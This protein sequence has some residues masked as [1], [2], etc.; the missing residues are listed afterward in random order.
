MT[1]VS[2]TTER[3][4]MKSLSLLLAATAMLVG[5]ASTAAGNGPLSECKGFI[6]DA[7]GRTLYTFKKDL[8]NQSN[9]F[10][11][12]AKVW[13]PFLVADRS[14][15]T[16]DLTVVERKDGTAQWAWKAQPLY[17]YSGDAE[18]RQVNGDGNGGTWFALR[19]ATQASTG[20]GY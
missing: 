15:A 7:Q 13:P 18:A 9:C 10:D 19:P 1:L 11:N 4:D 20:T 6:T 5:C 3:Q 8:P 14:K 17:R 12:C 16:S 2:S